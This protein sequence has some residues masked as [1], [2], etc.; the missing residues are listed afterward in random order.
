MSTFRVI[1]AAPHHAFN[2]GDI[3]SP[4][5]AQHPAREFMT[6]MATALGTLDAI[7]ERGA[8]PYERESD[9]AVQILDSDDIEPTGVGEGIAPAG[10]TLH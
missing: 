5:P 9:H 1:K 8:Q 3:V 6:I 2:V 4:V 10:T 7:K